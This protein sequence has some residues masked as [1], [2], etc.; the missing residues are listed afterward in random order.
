MQATCEEEEVYL[1]HSFRG[2]GFDAGVGSVPVR[3][4]LGCDTPA[5]RWCLHSMISW[6]LAYTKKLFL[7]TGQD[8]GFTIPSDAMALQ[9]KDLPLSGSS[10]RASASQQYH[11][12]DQAITHSGP[13]GITEQYQTPIYK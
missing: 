11:I 9:S 13:L 7:Q 5:D 12:A 6:K 3:G 4:L 1:P 10:E 8:W 2:A